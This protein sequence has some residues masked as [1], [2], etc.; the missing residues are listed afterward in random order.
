M[1][2][3][4]SDRPGTLWSWDPYYRGRGNYVAN[5]GDQ[6]L[7]AVSPLPPADGPFGWVS[8][9]GFGGY[10]PYRRSLVA[11]DRRDLEHADAVRARDPGPGQRPGR[12]R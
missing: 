12:P 9:G 8:S 4:P 6:L 7:F 5:Y 2:Y 3:C 1:Y 10:V 11:H